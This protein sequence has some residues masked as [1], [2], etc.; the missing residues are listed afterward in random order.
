MNDINSSPLPLRLVE[1]ISSNGIPLEF[2]KQTTSQN[3]KIVSKGV[4]NELLLRPQIINEH[5]EVGDTVQDV[6]DSSTIV[7][8]IFKASQANINSITVKLE[9]A[10]QAMIDDFES[11]ADS[12]ALQAA[13]ALTGTNEAI[14][15]TDTP[16][17][18]TKHMDLPSDTVDDEWEK[19]I[20]SRDCTGGVWKMAVY[21]DEDYAKQNFDFFVSDGTNTKSI[22]IV[23][24]IKDQWQ[25]IYIPQASM[26]DDGGTPCD[27]SA[28]VGVG[29][30][31]QVAKADRYYGVDV[32]Q[33]APP[34]G[35][36]RFKLWDMGA[37]IP[38]AGVTKI[39]DGTQKNLGDLDVGSLVSQIDIDLIGGIRR[40]QL[41]DF[42]AGVN[43]GKGGNQPLT[44]DNYYAITMHYIDTNVSVH[45]SSGSQNFY[46]NGFSFTAPD[47]ATAITAVG[48]NKDCLFQIYS[49]QEVYLVSSRV[50]FKNTTGALID[51]GINSS[52][53]IFVETP[54]ETLENMI[55][56]KIQA[57]V[58]E[59]SSWFR[60]VQMLA[61]GKL[62]IY[63]NDDFNDDVYKM[64]LIAEYA[65]EPKAANG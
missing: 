39:N 22:N 36:V 32:L 12:A 31:N 64:Y 62:E 8:Q 17:Q 21:P 54:S 1:T 4:L 16:Y 28:I 25:V 29:F 51:N 53:E 19:T 43:I 63:F 40:Y 37:T 48:A 35:Q 38:E 50:Y 23:T 6:I 11:Y 26:S 2:T 60:P 3:Q 47:Q 30:R 24:T 49:V 45:G 65:Y 9:S 57:G 44:V 52:Y 15:G 58:I 14:L 46:N 27:D 55:T 33:F 5:M 10:D 61:G 59:P 13:W 56:S 34:A 18:G 41:D 20:S 7:G 42:I